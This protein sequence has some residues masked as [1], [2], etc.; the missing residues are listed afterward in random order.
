MYKCHHIIN[1]MSQLGT[2][3]IEEGIIAMFAVIFVM[4]CTP[5]IVRDY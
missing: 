4:T 1:A 5:I 3:C 2:Y